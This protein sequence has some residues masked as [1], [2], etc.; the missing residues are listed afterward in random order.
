MRVSFQQDVVDQAGR[1]DA[2]GDGEGRAVEVGDGDVVGLDPGRG[3]DGSRAR[4]GRA[5][6]ARAGSR[7]P[8]ARSSGERRPLRD[9]SASP[10][11]SRTVGTTR[12]SSSRF[13]SRTTCFTTAT[14]CAS[15]RPKYARSRPDDREELQAD[16]RD[17][18]EV[19]G[20][21]TRPRG[22]R[23][24]PRA[25][26]RSRTRAGR[27]RRPTARTAT[28]TPGV[29][30]R[31][32]RRRR[33][34]AGRRRGRR[35]SANCAGL[36]NTLA[37][38][39]SHSSRAAANSATWPAWSAPIVGTSPI[40]ARYAHGSERMPQLARSCCSVFICRLQFRGRIPGTGSRSRCRPMRSAPSRR[41]CVL[42]ATWYA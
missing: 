16:G 14:C 13:R 41:R 7:A 36:T 31:R 1:A 27:A 30:G 33:G 37:T 18:A 28:S 10:S 5:S 25:R 17:A 29:V 15:L 40:V 32:A 35:R 38:T 21:V 20:S 22:P 6:R 9:E 42:G 26:P 23:R 3:E 8:G 24:R 34:R 11:A 2:G 12:I 19:A 4:R 39:M